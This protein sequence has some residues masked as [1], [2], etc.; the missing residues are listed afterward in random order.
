MH[1]GAIKNGDK[2]EGVVQVFAAPS[3]DR[4]GVA[5]SYFVAGFLRNGEAVSVPVPETW[6]DS[7]HN[8]FFPIRRE[9]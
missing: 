6:S 8:F 4:D 2:N 3:L 7:D 5:T 1:C 9:T